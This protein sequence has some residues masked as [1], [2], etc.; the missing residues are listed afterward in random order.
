MILPTKRKKTLAYYC[1]VHLLPDGYLTY[2]IMV[3][4]SDRIPVIRDQ[5]IVRE[6]EH[7]SG[8]EGSDE[9]DGQDESVSE[10]SLGGEDLEISSHL[11]RQEI[12]GNFTEISVMY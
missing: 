12:G 11:G 4:Q 1:V 6:V 7:L 9:K 5:H 8:L 2:P 10:E 3:R